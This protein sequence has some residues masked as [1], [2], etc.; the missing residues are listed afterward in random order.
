[1]TMAKT[2]RLEIRTDDATE[3]LINEAAELLQVSKTTFVEDAVRTAAR[4]VIA[5][6]DSTLMDA[7]VFDSMMSTLERADEAPGLAD[8][9]RLPRLIGR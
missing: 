6:S 2:R 9:A 5:R 1:M 7:D 4:R 3:E 8:L